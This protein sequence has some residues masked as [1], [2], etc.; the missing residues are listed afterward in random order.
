V[1]RLEQWLIRNHGYQAQYAV[2][3]LSE[4]DFWRMFDPSHYEH[5]R[6]KYGAVG[7]FMSAHYKSK[8]GKKSEEEVLEAEAAILEPA[9]ADAE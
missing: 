5:C 4:K 1:H 9:D 6:R 7:T 8:K 3:E 2:S